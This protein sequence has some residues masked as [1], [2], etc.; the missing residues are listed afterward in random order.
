MKKIFLTLTFIV[1]FPISSFSTGFSFPNFDVKQPDKLCKDEWTKR[2][3]LDERMYNYCMNQ[4]EE[5]YKKALNIYNEFKT[6]EWIDDVVK[7]SYDQWTKRGN[8]NYRMFAYRMNLEKEGFLDLEYGIQ[9]GNFTESNIKKCTNKW[10][11]Q[12]RMIVYC[13]NN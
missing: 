4:A 13:L 10:Y 7:H 11:P 3:V 2:G 8:T 1:F 6:E 9:Q 5:G 12:F